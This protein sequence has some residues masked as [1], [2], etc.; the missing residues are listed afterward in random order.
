VQGQQTPLLGWMPIEHRPIPTIRFRKVQGA[1]AIFATFLYPYLDHAPTFAATPLTTTGDD[2]WSRI[3]KTSHETAEIVLAKKGAAEPITLTS[4]LLGDVAVNASGLIL[5]QPAGSKV[6]YVGGMDLTS[7]RD[8]QVELTLDKPASLVFSR[9]ED[10]LLCFNPTDE[11]IALTVKKPFASAVTLPPQAWTSVTGSSTSPAPAPVI[12]QP[13]ESSSSSVGYDKYLKSF[14]DSPSAPGSA[15]IKIAAESL[16]L[17]AGAVLVGKT[18]AD[19]KVL[20]RWDQNGTVAT[21]H[22]DV[23]QSGWYRLKVRYCSADMP[24][25]S[26][27]IDGKIPFTEVEDFSLPSTVG[28]SPSDGWSN[29]SNDWHELVLGAEQATPG[30]KIYLK[31]GPCV[32]DLRNDGGGLNLDWLELDPS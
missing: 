16:T 32:L 29:V 4:S 7:Y 11:S 30:W 9:E 17:P 24:M 15:P 2:I 3:L 18:G 20:G 28:E 25:R 14:P 21:A 27:L 19:G 22:I 31:K 1:P 5:R 6:T 10:H 8:G 12:F 26:L 23:P 13:L